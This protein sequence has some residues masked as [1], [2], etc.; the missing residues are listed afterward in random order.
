MKF[1]DATAWLSG[2]DAMFGLE[3]YVN[4][5]QHKEYRLVHICKKNGNL[6]PDV[7]FTSASIEDLLAQIPESSAVAL[8][9]N[10]K[11]VIHR[12]FTSKETSTAEI[13]KTLFPD[14]KADEFLCQQTKTAS[15]GILSLIR[16]ELL[17]ELLQQFE[18]KKICV[19]A[20]SVGPFT[21][22]SLLQL[23]HQ[24]SKDIRYDYYHIHT[25]DQGDIIQYEILPEKHSASITIADEHIEGSYLNAFAAVCLYLLIPQEQAEYPKI[26]DE[27]IS[28]QLK[29]Y[30]DTILKKRGGLVFLSV[31]LVIL[32]INFFV[33]SNLR[34][35]NGICQDQLAVS[36]S[37]LKQLDSLE[38]FIKTKKTFLEKAGWIEKVIVS[39]E[40]DEI[41]QTVPAEIR[42]TE[43]TIHPVNIAE[44]RNAKETIFSNKKIIIR[45]VTKKV[46]AL[47]DWLKIVGQRAS[48]K[49]LHMEEYHFD[50]QTQEGQFKLEGKID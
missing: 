28:I 8:V 29:K 6:I 17:N 7:F 2:T 36:Q 33:F 48:I 23:V 42:L 9:W 25:N 45:G 21:A 31:I 37:Q 26:E 1:T 35:A 10:G 46:T 20:F 4:K 5:E 34:K 27:L 11:G 40:C 39:K 49:D 15:G 12:A 32:L 43:L 30:K 38:N 47:N 19:V 41:A 44:S 50:T 14:I 18:Q 24:F 3:V 16:K 13:A 22:S